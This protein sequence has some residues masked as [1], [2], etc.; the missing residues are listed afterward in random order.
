MDSL[1]AIVG[2]LSPLTSE[3]RV[4]VVRAAMAFLGEELPGAATAAAADQ[5]ITS[6]GLPPKAML[7]MKQNA[8]TDDQLEQAFHIADG[9]ADFIGTLPG[10][11]KRE[12]SLNAYVM[13]G[14]AQL[15]MKGEASFDDKSARGICESAGC[16]NSGNHSSTLK[17]RGNELAGSKDR[18]G[19]SRRPA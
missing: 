2:V 10:A 13:A 6:I 3:E 17:A 5:A 11:N 8:L 1:G 19:L 16:Y 12:Q 9:A 15:L 14:V 18:V 7:W 4:R